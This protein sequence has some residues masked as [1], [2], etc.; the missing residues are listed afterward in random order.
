MDT[1]LWMFTDPTP[2]VIVSVPVELRTL[3]CLCVHTDCP[4]QDLLLHILIV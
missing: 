1:A 2:P 3:P 4:A